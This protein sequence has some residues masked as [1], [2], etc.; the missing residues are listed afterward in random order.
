MAFA[1]SNSYLG[2]GL[3]AT[4]GT[5]AATV[6]DYKWIPIQTPTLTPVRQFLKDDAFRGSPATTYDGVQSTWYTEIDT[7]GYVYADTFPILAIA[8][9]GP[10][11]VTGS[12]PYL[13]TIK[14]ANAAA[15]GSQPASLTVDYF[16]GV[17]PW[18]VVG[19]QPADFTVT[20]GA[21]KALEWS[22][23]LMGYAWTV[24]GSA[25]TESF[26]TIPLM[27]GWDVT[28]TVNSISLNY[29]EDFT[30][31]IDRK[32]APIFTQGNSSPLVIFTG[33]CDVTGTLTYVVPTVTD[34]F[35]VGGSAWALYREQIPF[36]I[37][38]T[39]PN[40]ASTSV[41]FTMTTVQFQTIKRE[42]TGPYVKATVEFFAEANT[43]DALTGYS[44]IAITVDNGVAAYTAS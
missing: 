5:A 30:L 44:P 3:E 35:A 18:Q 11:V 2:V 17:N 39:D 19:A 20:G 43:T 27:P 12:A 42:T 1:S 25:P 8:T 23:K 21:D 32:T 38:C 7:K 37:A 33:P 16:D 22:S 40:T 36:V 6:G 34:P 9:L 15:T 14:L 13:H 29:I 28:S 10:D 31:K 41:T 4:R 24:L 26:S